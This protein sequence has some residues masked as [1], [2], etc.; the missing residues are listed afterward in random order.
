MNPWEPYLSLAYALFNLTVLAALL[1]Y[2]LWGVRV[3]IGS[4]YRRP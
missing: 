3:L 2:V 4:R 1:G